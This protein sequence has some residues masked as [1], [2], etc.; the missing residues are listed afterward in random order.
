MTS[1]ILKTQN[2]E[3]GFWGTTAIHYSEKQTQKRWNDVFKTLLDLSGLESE[4]I[5][6]L[7][8][9]RIGR[10]LADQCYKEKDV[11]QVTK[12]CYFNWLE[13]YLFNEEGKPIETDKSTVLF[14]TKVRNRINNNLDILL[15]TYKNKNRIYQDYAVCI[16][17]NLKQY[18]ISMDYIEPIE[19]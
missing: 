14:G 13:K 11:K 7:L 3:H 15:Y 6:E 2:E 4:N 17:K 12:E 5:R 16:N 1:K 19:E 8:D 18:R 9:D 10:H